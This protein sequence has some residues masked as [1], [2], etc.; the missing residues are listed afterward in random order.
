MATLVVEPAGVVELVIYM[1]VMADVALA[2]RWCDVVH[3]A[4]GADEND[5]RTLGRPL[6]GLNA[7][8][9]FGERHGFSA[10]GHGEEVDLRFWQVRGGRLGGARGNHRQRFAIRTRGE[11]ELKPSALRRRGVKEPSIGTN[12]M[13]DSRWFFFWLTMVRT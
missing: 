4:R 6:V 3:R 5:T 7:V 10:D 8:F 1:R 11:L 12:Q 13:E 2:I 9:E